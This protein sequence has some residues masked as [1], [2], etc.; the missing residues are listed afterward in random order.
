MLDG[1][2]AGR[3][4]EKGK[5]AGGRVLVE[6]KTGGQVGRVLEEPWRD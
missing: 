3:V 2:T 5:N 6:G 4:L 1:E